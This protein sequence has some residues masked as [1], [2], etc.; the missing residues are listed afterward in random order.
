MRSWVVIYPLYAAFLLFSAVDLAVILIFAALLGLEPTFGRHWAVG[1]G[2]ILSNLAG[3]LVAV[4]VYNVLVWVPAY[5]FFLLLVTLAG[6]IVGRLIFSGSALGKLFAGGITTVFIVL[7]PTLTGDAEAGAQLYI[8]VLLILSAVVY[9]VVA[10][11]T[12]ERLTGGRRVE[13]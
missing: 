10:F 7:G 8:R 5:P 13:V 6:L 12:L 4:I 9:V 2:M 11:A 3:G 1:K